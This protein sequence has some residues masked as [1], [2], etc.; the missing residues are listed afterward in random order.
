MPETSFYPALA[1]L[2][3]EIGKGLSPK[4]RYVT[5]MC[6]RLAALLALQPDLDANYRSVSQTTHPWT[7]DDHGRP[8]AET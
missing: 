8:T 5:E 6:R 2:L 3:N 1:N 7:K 4:V